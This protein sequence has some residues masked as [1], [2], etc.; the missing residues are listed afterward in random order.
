MNKDLIT[1]LHQLEYHSKSKIRCFRTK[2]TNFNLKFLFLLKKFGYIKN[3][4]WSISS[5]VIL[6]F[7]GY[8]WNSKKIIKSIKV[9]SSSSVFYSITAKDLLELKQQNSIGNFFLS[10]S[11][12]VLI[13]TEALKHEIGGKLICW[14]I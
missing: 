6:V 11:K 1:L 9:L 2:K 13:D 14:I 4:K 7:L 12:G 3:I 10:T 5:D 8:K